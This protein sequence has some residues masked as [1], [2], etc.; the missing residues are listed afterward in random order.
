VPEV[1]AQNR[2][3]E[4]VLEGEDRRPGEEHHEAI[5]DEE[6]ADAC[7]WVAP[8]DPCVGDDDLPHP[9]QALA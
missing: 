9:H 1:E 6:V 5:E 2:L 8:F 3:G 7:E 4:V